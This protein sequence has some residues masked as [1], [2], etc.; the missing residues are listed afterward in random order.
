MAQ[1]RLVVAQLL[2]KYDISFAPG[3]NNGEAV[4]RD[5]K[6]QT[7]ANPGKLVLIF[8]KRMY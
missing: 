8:S 6:D 4:E 3:E 2:S 5:M 1:L 7:T